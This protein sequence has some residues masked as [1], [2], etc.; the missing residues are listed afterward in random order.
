[1]PQP[2]TYETRTI[3]A[4]Y[5]L[6]QEDDYPEHIF[7]SQRFLLLITKPQVSSTNSGNSLYYHLKGVLVAPKHLNQLPSLKERRERVLRQEL[8]TSLLPA[9]YGPQSK[10]IKGQ[11]SGC[12]TRP[13][14]SSLY[15]KVRTRTGQIGTWFLVV[16]VRFIDRNG[17]NNRYWL[18]KIETALARI[19]EQT[20][21][22][23][24]A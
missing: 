20:S 16:R 5:D 21:R 7:R 14:A 18:E 23:Y 1:M 6:S 22:L 11:R 17:T 8:P 19:I 13:K 9:G 24:T 3:S 10:L 2:I 12:D 15:R 4:I